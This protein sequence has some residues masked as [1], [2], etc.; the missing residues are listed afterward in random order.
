MTDS[1]TSPMQDRPILC[2]KCR[3]DLRAASFGDGSLPPAGNCPECGTDYDIHK[4]ATLW[5][6][7]RRLRWALK[8][9][10]WWWQVAAVGAT[11]WMIFDVSDLYMKQSRQINLLW[12]WLLYGIMFVWKRR[13][14]RRAREG[15]ISLWARS[16]S[17]RIMWLLGPVCFLIFLITGSINWPF[18]LRFAISEP[19]LRAH[20]IE[21][22]NTIQE[23]EI[24]LGTVDEADTPEW[25]GLFYIYP[26]VKSRLDRNDQGYH[27]FQTRDFEY[28]SVV[29]MEYSIIED[30][31]GIPNP[32]RKGT[33]FGYRNAVTTFV[34]PIG[35]SKDNEDV[36][37]DYSNEMRP[38]MGNWYRP[39]LSP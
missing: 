19:F 29:L 18:Y 38:L 15:P 20:A 34:Y 3:Y 14:L 10:R 6:P 5:I 35:L 28:E 1:Q 13:E 36:I 22:F 25:V 26:R 8:G 31:Y 30:S 24:H 11:V 21:R 12:F 27:G 37:E 9:I 2:R 39:Y 7:E 16:K 4:P 32:W 33:L 17:S 23:T